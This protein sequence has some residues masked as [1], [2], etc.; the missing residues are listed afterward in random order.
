MAII[1]PSLGHGW[2]HGLLMSKHLTLIFDTL[3]LSAFHIKW[4][5]NIRKDQATFSSV[6]LSVVFFRQN[7]VVFLSL[8]WLVRRACLDLIFPTDR[9]LLSL[10]RCQTPN[11]GCQVLLLVAKKSQVPVVTSGRKSTLNKSTPGSFGP[12]SGQSDCF[13]AFSGLCVTRFS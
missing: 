13:A 2:M 3:T 10:A 11:D 8:T 7:I 5:M 12:K 6:L 1:V 4:E 9:R